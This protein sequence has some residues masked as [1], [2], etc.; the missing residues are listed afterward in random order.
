M[1]HLTLKQRL[2]ALVGSFVVAFSIFGI[3]AWQSLSELKINGPL[4]QRIVQGKDLIADILP[5]PEYII[6]SYLVVLQLAEV[7]ESADLNEVQ[8]LI[9]RLKTLQQ[10][11][12]TRHT[13]WQGEHLEPELQEMFL[14]QAHLPAESFYR[15]LNQQ[16]LPLFQQG[17]LPDRAV[18]APILAELKTRYVAHRS[19]IDKVVEFATLRNKDD[20][21]RAAEAIER[22]A[23]ELLTLFLGALALSIFLTITISRNLLRSVGG[24]LEQ[25]IQAARDM[26]QGQ[27]AMV[28]P[29][30]SGDKDSLLA[31]IETMRQELLA[32]VRKILEDAAALAEASRALVSEASAIEQSSEQQSDSAS[33]VAAAVEQMSAGMHGLHSSAERAREF[34]VQAG[35]LSEKGAQSLTMASDNLSATAH[36][37]QGVSG[38]VVQL[39]VEADHISSIAGVIK[40]IAGQTNLLALNAAIEAA[41][42]GEQGRGFAV[43]ADE[44]RKLSERTS[45]STAEISSML[46]SI[47]R[48][49]SQAVSQIVESVERVDQ[50]AKLASDSNQVILQLESGAH[51]VL[52][53]L[54][55]VSVAL[56]EQSAATSEIS[57]HIARIADRAEVNHAAIRR[58][59]A[60]ARHL[61]DL[62]DALKSR[63]QHLRV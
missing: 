12:D 46:Q 3:Y 37:V 33:S 39:N 6:E 24:E 40:D 29:L 16:F 19:A 41:R 55:E 43:V 48:S 45:Q 25:A 51:Q 9:A 53:V 1:R 59:T 31:S 23:L 28:V 4:Y 32:L 47:Q 8:P 7:R 62:S 11:Y 50:G 26:A 52:S 27:L 49:T 63:V 20:E 44:V 17:T 57:N 15:T 60:S 58:S 22:T 38:V 2:A 5:P 42:A 30:R 10:D 61:Q 34:A 21:A 56:R 54:N 35:S 14:Q 13:F 18:L 36:T